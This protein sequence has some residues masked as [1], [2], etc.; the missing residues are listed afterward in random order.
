MAAHGITG[1]KRKRIVRELR[2]RDG[3]YCQHCR[4][5]FGKP[6]PSTIDHIHPWSMGGTNALSNLQLLCYPCN[7]KRDLWIRFVLPDSRAA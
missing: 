6:L 7:K 3:N 2:M 1:N 4:K 5:P